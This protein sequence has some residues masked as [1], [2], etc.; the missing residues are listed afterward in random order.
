[1]GTT[2]LASRVYQMWPLG[3]FLLRG[4]RIGASG[5]RCSGWSLWLLS[6]NPALTGALWM[7][8]RR[9]VPVSNGGLD[10]RRLHYWIR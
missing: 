4:L 1:M 8:A 2:Q 3:G 9:K 6:G 10:C 7:K 5:E